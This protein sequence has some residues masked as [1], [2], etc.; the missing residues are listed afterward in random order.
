MDRRILAI[1]ILVASLITSG[2]TAPLAFAQGTPDIH[3]EVNR[4]GGMISLKGL[5]HHPM[6]PSPSNP[7]SIREHPPAH[8]LKFIGS[9]F[10]GP[11]QSSGTLSAPYGPSTI[12]TAYGFSGL[13]CMQTGPTWPSPGLCGNG[14]T[15]AIVDAYNDPKI[16]SDLQTFDAQFG[17]PP[18]TTANGC[19]VASAAGPGS[20][21]GWALETSLDVEWAHSIAPGAKIV[22]VESSDSS[23]GN[24]LKGEKAAAGSG[25]RQISNSWG[26]GEFSGETSYDSYFSSPTASF[27]VSSG[28]GGNGVE[29][30]AASPNVVSVGGTTLALDA[31]GTW[32]G[33]TAW[34]DS[35]GG[36]SAYEPKPS[37]QDGLVSGNF[38]AVPDVAYD[39]DPNTG[40]YVYDSVPINGQSGWWEVGGTSAGA[41]Q[42]A[43]L[44]AIAN[45]QGA[46]LASA[47]ADNALYGAAAGIPYASNY[48]DITTGTNG[49][50]GTV[51]DAAP[52]YDEVTGLGSP[53]A[54]SLI[55]FLSGPPAPGFTVSSSP[56]SL[57]I[58]ASGNASSTITVSSVNG[59]SVSVALSASAASGS[60]TLSSPSVT[61]SSGGTATDTLDVSAPATPGTY[62]VTVTGT[63]G[64]TQTTTVTVPVHAAPSAPQNLVASGGNSQ[65]SLSWQAPS[66][67]GGSAIT[68]YNIYRGTASGGEGTTPYATGITSTSYIDKNATNGHTYF[69]AVTAVNAAGE[70]GKSNEASATP[71][72][73]PA[74]SVAVS[75]NKISYS[76]GSKAY[77]TVTVTTDSKGVNRA[78][79][80]LTVTE[81]NGSTAKASG[82]TNSNGQVTFSYA[83]GKSSPAGTY[84]AAATASSQGYISGSGSTTFQV[85]SSS[86]QG[87]GP[88]HA[89]S[90]DVIPGN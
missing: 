65:V 67:N 30:P 25:A 75:T 4:P 51:C 50:C 70:S 8:I 48:H 72:A 45:S 35:S 60:A 68:G 54:N 58:L 64:L 37:Y 15:I 34:L 3:D 14:Q 41:P 86:S 78:A 73:A 62:Q 26:S 82:N 32:Q 19:L 9:K 44:S 55:P 49:N 77:I 39:G 42:W 80:T 53:Q 27:F 18:C 84:T 46:N 47:G 24:L 10:A 66:S 85:V 81:P 90:L 20:N 7:L 22:L 17:L 2:V 13:D 12:W 79:V 28:D 43:G 23:L 21:S 31:S 61:V 88:R 76:T 87:P 83:I 59:F 38:R 57:T 63:G 33:E 5:P 74:L 52:G 16:A 56:S 11:L 29:W 89:N 69:Y 6:V 1:T 40:L 36:I 71:A